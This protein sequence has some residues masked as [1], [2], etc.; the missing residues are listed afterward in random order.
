[1]L[2]RSKLSLESESCG[3]TAASIVKNYG[4]TW[5]W[6]GKSGRKV[7][8]WA[9][10]SKFLAGLRTA[11]DDSCGDSP[12]EAKKQIKLKVRDAK[13]YSTYMDAYLVL[14]AK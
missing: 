4:L 8:C 1:M 5:R 7:E 3:V 10:T 12:G 6:L 11:M 2:Q 9:D 14:R 13:F